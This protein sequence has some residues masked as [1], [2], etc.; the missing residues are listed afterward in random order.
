MKLES[1]TKKELNDLAKKHDIKRRSVMT[2]PELIKAIN[3]VMKKSGVQ[4]LKQKTPAVGYEAATKPLPVLKAKTP[5]PIPSYYVAPYY[6]QDIIF[7]LPVSPGSEYVYWEVSPDTD[8][9]L[10]NNLELEKCQ[11]EL[12][13][14]CKDKTGQ[15]MLAHCSVSSR[16]DYY[17]GL[18]APLKTLWAELGVWDKHGRFH[19]VMNS[20]YI[21][22]PSDVV[23]NNVDTE[24]MMI[25]DSWENVYKL[26]GVDETKYSGGASMPDHIVRRIR[27]F[28][29]SSFQGDKR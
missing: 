12:R 20:A 15:Q 14:H 11:Y 29:E 2:K 10:K 16:G 17:F 3:D 9:R 5:E 4:K 1:M 8:N 23:S 19:S 22:M 6:H 21:I 7:F 18:W 28:T 26:S 24:W 27:E 13:I 25:T